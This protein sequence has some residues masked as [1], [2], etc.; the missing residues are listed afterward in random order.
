MLGRLGGLARLVRGRNYHFRQQ[1]FKPYGLT[2]F[3][4]D[5]AAYASDTGYTAFRFATLVPD[6]VLHRCAE[7]FMPSSR[8]TFLLALAA[9]TLTVM[10]GLVQGQP[11]ALPGSSRVLQLRREQQGMPAPVETAVKIHPA[12]ELL[13]TAGDDHKL[14]VWNLADGTLRHELTGHLD[15]VRTLAFS[16][17]GGLL[18]S[19]GNDRRILFWDAASGQ[20]TRDFA[21]LPYAV[22]SLEFN[23][24]GSLLGVVGFSKTVTLL[25]VKTGNV[26]AELEGPDGDLRVVA[27]SPD[28]KTLAAAGRSGTIRM[29]DLES[30]RVIRDVAAHTQRVRSLL[31]TPDGV[32][33]ISGG[34]DRRV[35][36]T[37]VSPGAES[38][39]LPRQSAKIFALAL[40]GNGHLAVAGSDHQIRLWNLQ[41]HELAGTL[42]GHEG[43]VAT[44]H[45]RDNVLLSGGF[46]T[47]VRIWSIAPQ[48]A[49]K[50]GPQ[51]D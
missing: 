6:S 26:H 46:D 1:R 45:G 2:S 3:L 35:Q 30:G 13:V 48:V 43:S 25:D 42:G 38:L 49:A 18:A 12:G 37:P 11:H 9:L 17:D 4:C 34:E 16:T 36:I 22:A 28:G 32:A 5:S 40:C 41:T 44:L 14:A 29:W 33:L 27:F 19:S 15:W 21:S 7:L 31:F 39:S 20:R 8:R 47:T 51:L 24:A 50:P 10:P 23:P